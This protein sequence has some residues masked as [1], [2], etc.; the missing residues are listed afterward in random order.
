ML[1][2]QKG[3]CKGPGAGVSFLRNSGAQGGW[4][5]QQG[6]GSGKV[7]SPPGPMS[8]EGWAPLAWPPGGGTSGSSPPPLSPRGRRLCDL[9]QS[10]PVSGPLVLSADRE[11]RDRGEA[12]AGMRGSVSPWPTR[13]PLGHARRGSGHR[14]RRP[15]GLGLLGAFCSLLP[16]G[17]HA[18]RGA[19][20]PVDRGPG[21]GSGCR[22]A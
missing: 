5:A 1:G 21:W 6:Q 17:E 18:P 22:A 2:L 9:Q 20:Q 14:R 11:W 13:C 15:R 7:V 3:L 4:R 8:Q 10:L 16:P 12:P 19:S